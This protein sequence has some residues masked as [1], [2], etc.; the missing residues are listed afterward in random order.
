MD[1]RKAAVL[2]SRM[3]FRPSVLRVRGQRESATFAAL[4]QDPETAEFEAHR[5]FGHGIHG[6]RV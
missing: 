4:R 6:R 3:R 5:R 2:G 1:I